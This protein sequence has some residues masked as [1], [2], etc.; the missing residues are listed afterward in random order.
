MTRS[1]VVWAPRPLDDLG[2][3]TGIVECDEDVAER[4]IAADLAQDPRIGDRLLRPIDTK[5]ARRAA[6]AA[7]DAAP[8]KPR[9]I[10]K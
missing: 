6:P 8:A 7:P 2:G 1:T 10:V 5:P 3:A 9:R 4:L